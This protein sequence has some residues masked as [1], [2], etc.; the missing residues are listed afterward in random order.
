MIE[1]DELEIVKTRNGLLPKLDLF[2]NMGKSGYASSFVGSVD[3]RPPAKGHASYPQA[4]RG[5]EGG[6]HGG[7]CDSSRISEEDMGGPDLLAA[8]LRPHAVSGRT[9]RCGTSVPHEDGSSQEG[10]ECIR[11]VAGCPGSSA[12]IPWRQ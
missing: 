12:A 11:A 2:V 7:T 1:R 4:L 8:F 9:S 5:E 10:A 3:K 6:D